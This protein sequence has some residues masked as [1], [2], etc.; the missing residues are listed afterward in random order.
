MDVRT[1]NCDIDAYAANIFKKYSETV[2]ADDYDEVSH[3]IGDHCWIATFFSSSS[4]TT[5]ARFSL[6]EEKELSTESTR[7]STLSRPITPD[8]DLEPL[9]YVFKLFVALHIVI[10]QGFFTELGVQGRAHRQRDHDPLQVPCKS[11][12]TRLH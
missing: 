5:T 3:G 11:P 1:A 9:R 8:S 12:R 4:T 2:F 7:S 6:R 10:E